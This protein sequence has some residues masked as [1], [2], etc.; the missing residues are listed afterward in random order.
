MYVCT[1]I[2]L[3]VHACDC[4]CVCEHGA[5]LSLAACSP[6]YPACNKHALYCLRRLWLHHVSSYYL[7]KDTILENMLLNIKYVL[8]FSKAFVWNIS[9][10]KKNSAKCCH[11]F[12]SDLDSC[13]ILSK[14]KF[15]RQIFEKAQISNFIKIRPVEAELFH[16]NRRTYRWTDMTKL[17]VAFRNFANVPKNISTRINRIFFLIKIKVKSQLR[18]TYSFRLINSKERLS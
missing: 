9:H 10:S 17:I 18:S 11:L 5:G 2:G 6:V 4:M 1:C 8:R 15:S 3:W 16:V 7:I 13:R 12:I 14:Y